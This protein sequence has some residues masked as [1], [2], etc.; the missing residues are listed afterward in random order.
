[1]RYDD[2]PKLSTW[3]N[4]TSILRKSASGSVLDKIDA[5]IDN[6]HKAYAVM[7]KRNLLTD[8]SLSIRKWEGIQGTTV[9]FQT[10][11]VALKEVVARKLLS[12]APSAFKYRQAT[13]LAFNIGLN[14]GANYF[15]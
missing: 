11:V 1:M 10:N 3:K 12:L 9:S 14:N 6:Y 5:D 4:D 13:C 2:I 7:T 8:I 15:A